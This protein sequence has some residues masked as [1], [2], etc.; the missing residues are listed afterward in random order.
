[1]SDELSSE[2]GAS[3]AR[4]M[5][6]QTASRVS[7]RNRSPIRR[8]ARRDG[9]D[10]SALSSREV[11]T[12][13][14]SSVS[15]DPTPVRRGTGIAQARA[16][17]RNAKEE[18]IEQAFDQ[19][20]RD[21]VY[22]KEAVV[23]VLD[24]EEWFET[25]TSNNEDPG[26]LN[27][28]ELR[29]A[30]GRRA[31]A[32]I[33]V[34]TKS[35]HLK[36]T[37]VKCLKESASA[38]QNFVDTLVN[39][40]ESEE[41][42]RLRLDNT[43]LRNEVD[44]LKAE[45]KA[46][47]REFV[48][49][50]TSMAAANRTTTPTLNVDIIEE[51]KASIVAS[52]GV[53]LDARFAGI[54]ERLL[55]ERVIRPPLASDNRRPEAPPPRSAAAPPKSKK[56]PE[57][58]NGDARSASPE[59]S[60]AAT[61]SSR[62][63]V[64]EVAGWSTVVRRGK[65]GKKA[66][67]SSN[68]ASPEA[69]SAHTNRPTGPPTFTLP[70]TAAIIINL[71]P[72]AVKKGISYAEVLERAEQSINLQE[73]G[74]GEGIKIRRAATGARLLE[75]PKE[76]TPEQVELLVNRLRAALTGMATVVRPTKTASVRLMDLDDTVTGEKVIA[77]IARVGN[78]PVSCIKVG[79]IQSGPRG[80]GATTVH[81]PVEVVKVMSDAGKLLVGW[82]SARVQVLDQ[83][84]LRCYKCLC[85][86]HTRPLCPSLV[87]RSNLCFQCGGIGHKS[88][89]CSS[90]M[91]CAVC[92]DAGLPSGH[93]MGGRD[94]NPPPTRGTLDTSARSSEGLHQDEGEAN[95]SS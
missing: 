19:R 18:A 95:M 57:N 61:G 52:V 12:S 92:V 55:P 25:E 66:S 7:L 11:S 10:S 76:K 70:K 42:R 80:M 15:R 26:N 31:A 6:R 93:I 63:A 72:D 29:A 4:K 44:S 51:M 17:L 9:L 40:T 88:S 50:K 34:A 8:T 5:V 75:L 21:R 22:R 38:L 14:A 23:T 87:D 62:P 69:T 3:S 49:M 79:E 41:S 45:L 81:C 73:L 20:L 84:P 64:N 33:H 85:I 82:S 32:I 43:R 54:E 37:F 83:R 30:A 59:N 46:H 16:D 56:V 86:G 1:M 35:G 90:P 48:E 47:R 91:R 78:C 24:P 13:R 58:R 36:G 68:N 27:S 39:R 74:I 77:A 67:S 2:K 28:E 94:C 53:M 71:E 89:K 65:K 60:E